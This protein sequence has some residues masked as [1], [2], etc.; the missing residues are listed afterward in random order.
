MRFTA[1][2]LF[3]AAMFGVVAM[4]EAQ[5]PQG[6]D[7]GRPGFTGRGQ[8]GQVLPTFIQEA[9]KL[10]EE[11][12]KQVADLQKEIDEKIGKILTEDQQK[13][14]KEMRERGPGGFTRPGGDKGKRPGG[15]KAPAPPAKD[16]E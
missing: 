12:K 13:Q 16:S 8:S 2:A 11:Q 15:D 3:L 4:C 5:P 6:G 7:K 10:T 1:S 14:L 9:L